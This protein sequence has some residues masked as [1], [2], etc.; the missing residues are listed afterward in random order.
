MS[1]SRSRF[2]CCSSNRTA[3]AGKLRFQVCVALMPLHCTCRGGDFDW[4]ELVDT[5]APVVER[6]EVKIQ[7]T[8]LDNNNKYFELKEKQLL[9]KVVM[10]RGDSGGAQASDKAQVLGMRVL[11]AAGLDWV[12]WDFEKAKKEL[13]YTPVHHPLKEQVKDTAVFKGECEL[14]GAA[15]AAGAPA[16]A[17]GGAAAVAASASAGGGG[18][19]PVSS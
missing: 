18:G 14:S 11:G 9:F 4:K 1:R 6:R 16:P 5:E 3:T 15:G 8:F 10:V 2:T 7:D 13:E 17:E 12:V 19:G